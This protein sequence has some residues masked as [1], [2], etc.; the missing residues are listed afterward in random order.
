MKRDPVTIKDLA[1]ILQ[2]SPS[3]VS[4]A[5][6]DQ[7]DISEETK[8]RVK[9]LA[10]E[11]DYQPSSIA[12]GLVN[13]RTNTIG[14]VIPGFV[15]HFYASAITGIQE[16]A[17]A[18]GF[19]VIFCQSNENY[20]TE[21]SNLKALMANRVDGIIAS[22]SR[23]T[24]NLDHF[25]K[26]IDQNIP[27]VLFNRVSEDLA[28]PKVLVDDYE[29][30]YRATEH[31]IETGCRT[32]AHIAGPQGLLLTENRL[33]GFRDALR[34]YELPV[35]DNLI[36]HCD[37]TTQNAVDC[38]Q[39]LLWRHPRPDAI[40]AVCDAAAFGAIKYLKQNGIH[41]PDDV[42][43]VGFTDEPLAELIEPSL[44]TIAQPTFEIGKL[45]TFMLLDLIE[46]HTDPGSAQTVLLRTEL[47]QRRST[48][49]VLSSFK[50][51]LRKFAP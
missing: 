43:I 2:I 24:Q 6:R 11:L 39:R 20:E 37:F 35:Y 33:A 13:R 29:G 22:L 1:Q 14:V 44:T 27:L 32:I 47:I 38:T 4:R 15:I 21:Q 16:T 3:T 51:P 34:D 18:N 40:F 8:R 41:I 19:N 7:P 48:R 5:L 46:E 50:S 45:A 12:L 28:V 10:E 36:V 49:S 31:L 9:N 30:A 17:A 23:Q 25:R 42:S 26:L